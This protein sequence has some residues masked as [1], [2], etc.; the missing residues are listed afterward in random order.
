MALYVN[1]VSPETINK[2][3][4]QYLA[5]YATMADVAKKNKTS[6]GTVSNILYRGVVESILDDVTTAAVIEKAVAN[7]HDLHQ[8]DNRWKRAIKERELNIASSKLD[9]LIQK[10]QE[11][12]FQYETFDDY[13]ID[14]E[15]APSKEDIK[16]QLLHIEEEILCIHNYIN[17]IK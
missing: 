2:F 10:Q 6:S 15:G 13:A 1:K 3:A 12:Q 9:Y 16:Y 5:P 8:T 14:D 7:A 17:S 4:N 11:L